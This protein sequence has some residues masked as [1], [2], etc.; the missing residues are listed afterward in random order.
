MLIGM[1]WAAVALTGSARGQALDPSDVVVLATNSFD[2]QRR[3]Y[4][5]AVSPGAGFIPAGLAADGAGNMY[6]SDHGAA[7]F[8]GGIVMLPRDGR[9]PL[10]IMESLDQPSDIEVSPDGRSLVVAGPDGRVV[11]RYF[12][13]SVRVN[14]T[15]RASPQQPV[16]FINTQTATYVST[17]SA[18]G[19]FHFP[20]GLHPLQTSVTVDLTVRNG[21]RTYFAYG[22]RLQTV[23]GQ[24]R[25]HT[26]FD[27][28]ISE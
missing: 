2:G 22:R 12:G 24:L 14:F 23:G 17:L 5:A 10:R 8:D 11:T 7:A 20:G 15:G 28:T 16:V 26:I 27:V 13:V 3:V 1:A 18:D 25:G 19:Y 21:G 9:R 6:I 4:V